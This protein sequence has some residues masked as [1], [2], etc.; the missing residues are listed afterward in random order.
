[1]LMLP[2]EWTED[3]WPR[4]PANAD[5]TKIMV[6]PA[7]EDVGGGMPLSDSFSESELGIQWTWP[8]SHDARSYA[9]VGNGALRLKADG[10]LPGVAAV[11]PDANLL[12][13][14]P[15][16]HSYFAEVEV[17][18][19]A[20]AEAGLLLDNGSSAT[21]GWANVALRDDQVV[22]TWNGVANYVSTDA[23]RLFLRLRNIKGDVTGF[24]S[25][26]G[27]NWTQFANAT[28]VASGRRLAL[29]AAGSG[30]VVFRNFTYRGLE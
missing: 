3:G 6:K 10:E 27:K 14:V 18:I 1:V 28:R 26:D 21:S 17:E 12:A 5:A 29:Y 13:V 11:K 20:G 9:Q 16:N 19:P 22:A 2:I 8:S 30:E 7:G 24:Y 4:V 25:A 23:R 15:Q